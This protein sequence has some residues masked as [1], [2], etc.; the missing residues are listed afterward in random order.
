MQAN[1]TWEGPATVTGVLEAHEGNSAAGPLVFTITLNPDGT[2][3]YDQLIDISS[4]TTLH[5]SEF[6]A[7]GGGNVDAKAVDIPDSQ[8]DLMVSTKDGDSVNTNNTTFGVSDGQSFEAG[9]LIR[10]DLVQNAFTTGSGGGAVV[11]YGDYYTANGSSRTS[12]VSPAIRPPAS[13]SRRSLR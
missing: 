9:E 13:P 8:F 3:D 1:P 12:A 2:F 10:F 6:D 11:N 7:V 5:L 4:T